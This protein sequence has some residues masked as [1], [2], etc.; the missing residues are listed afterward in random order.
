MKERWKRVKGFEDYLIS[1]FGNVQSKRKNGSLRPLKIKLETTGYSRVTLY[2]DN[3][4]KTF[5]VHRLVATAFLPNSDLPQVNHK[6]GDKT[7][8]R[9]ENLEW[10]SVKENN[11]HA[12]RNGLRVM[13]KG[14]NVP[15]ALLKADDIH[16]I[17]LL[18]T[19]GLTHQDISE[20]FK[21]SRRTIGKVLSGETW[22][23]L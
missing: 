7:N 23:H 14:E 20:K 5:F 11:N 2:N 17:R 3:C 18:R 10:C 9:P 8:N 1:N 21:V 19:L 15:T 13:R 16:T 12:I 6:D 4:L 22:K